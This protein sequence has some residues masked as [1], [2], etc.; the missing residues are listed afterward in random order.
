MPDDQWSWSKPYTGSTPSGAPSLNWSD[1][2]AP[3][4]SIG[5]GLANLAASARQSMVGTPPAQS[6][7]GVQGLWSNVLAPSLRDLATWA[8]TM[9]GESVVGR[10]EG[11]FGRAIGGPQGAMNPSWG[12]VMPDGGP[13]DAPPTL[14]RPSNQNIGGPIRGGGASENLPNW[15]RV[16]P[17]RY[18]TRASNMNSLGPYQPHQMEDNDL[19]DAHTAHSKVSAELVRA[20]KILD[21]LESGKRSPM[22]YDEALLKQ[23]PAHWRQRLYDELLK[24]HNITKGLETEGRVRGLDFDA[25]RRDKAW[26]ERDAQD[27]PTSPTPDPSDY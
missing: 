24:N 27:E 8:P 14:P 7:Q 5:S 22:N 6:P 13:P 21:L 25:M 20:H 15:R 4:Q 10:G 18:D 17:T 9:L 23:N 19:F 16:A 1:L 12:E 3:Y 26:A 2:A 11:G